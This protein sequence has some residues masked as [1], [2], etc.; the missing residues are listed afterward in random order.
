MS[1]VRSGERSVVL[2]TGA[3]SGIGLEFARQMAPTA[4]ALVLVARR[5]ERLESLK[6]ELVR[7]HRELTVHVCGCDLTDREATRRMLSSIEHATGG[8]DVLVNNAGFGDLG[9]FDRADWDKTERM[10]TLNVTALTYLTH[11]LL[12]SM[13]S[14]GRGGILNLSSGFGLSFMPGFATYIGTKHYVTGFTESLRLDLAGT[15]VTV[16]QVCP[17]PVRTEFNDTLGNFTGVEP[18]SFVQISAE[19]CARAALRGFERGRALVIPGL[20][21]RVMMVLNA[22]SPRWLKRLLY[23]PIARRLRRVQVQQAKT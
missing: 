13:V 16:T 2:I 20:F 19:E 14:R 9:V 5:I 10:I 15:G 11:R 17:G 12:P 7:A 21:I 4:K 6:E 3:S 1:R 23:A 22:L 18:P 8:I